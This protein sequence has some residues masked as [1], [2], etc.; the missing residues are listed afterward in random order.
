M[1]ARVPRVEGAIGY[2]DLLFAKSRS[3]AYGAVQNKDRTAFIHAEPENL[4]AAAK[5]LI[6]NIPED[7]TFSLT[8]KP[9]TNSYPISGAVWAVCY[10]NQPE[11][12]QKTVVDFLHWVTHEGQQFTKDRTY[13]SLPDEF[14]KRV[15]EKLKLIK[16]V[17]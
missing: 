6:N 16:T 10:Q 2:V 9:G 7:L 12:T 15:E 17:P 14:V 8:S 13:A 1:A 5:T 3:I 11:S 4:T